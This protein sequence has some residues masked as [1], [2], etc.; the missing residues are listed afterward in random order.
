MGGKA[1]FM[2][3]PLFVLYG[4]SRMKYT[5]AHDNDFGAVARRL[6]VQRDILWGRHSHAWVIN[7]PTW[8]VEWKQI[9]PFLLWQ[10]Y[11]ATGTTD[12]AR[13]FEAQAYERTMIGF[14]DATGL[15]ATDKMGR[16]IVDWMP[17]ASESDETVRRGE[18]TNSNHT[19]VSNAFGAHGLELLA[20][21]LQNDTVGATAAALKAEIVKQMWNGTAFCDGPCD[22]VGGASKMMSNMFT[23]CFGM[24][25]EANVAANWQAVADWGMEQI[26]D[27]GA[28]WYQMALAGSYYAD[29][30]GAG[31]APFAI[32][33]GSAIY[34]ALTKCDEDSWCSGL[35]DDN[36]TMTRESWH[37]GT[38]S[39]EWG[40][41]AIVGVAWGIMGVHQTSPGW[42][43][44]TMKPKLGG[45]THATIKV[46]TLTG[47]I[48][49][50]AT[51]TTLEVEVPCN[52]AAQL[53]LPR[54]TED[55]AKRALL[56][57][58]EAPLSMNLQLDGGAVASFVEGGHVCTSEPVGCG[59]G[60]AA[61]LLAAL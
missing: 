15:L 47:Y 38:Y 39:H 28:F 7:D 44:F 54:S 8:P 12:L 50:T 41:S 17:D 5:E 20:H 34:T 40:T 1:I 10:D 19:S 26:G 61:R 24:V 25:P 18:F 58:L 52:S 56:G 2:I 36:L 32:D 31:A 16:H 22:A 51:P 43:N 9:T 60:G 13:A 57:A 3:V 29:A 37:S 33:D 35:R 48:T 4:A 46:P 53:C 27:Y 30:T 21:M 59:A 14:K 23:L 11:M 42:G 55:T 45:L 49:A 6:L